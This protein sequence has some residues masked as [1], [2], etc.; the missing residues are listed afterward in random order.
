MRLLSNRS[1]SVVA[2]SVIVLKR[3]LQVPCA[4]LRCR[5]W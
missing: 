4:L 5:V 2:E 3:L 1:D